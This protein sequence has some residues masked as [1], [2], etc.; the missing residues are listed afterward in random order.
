MRKITITRAKGGFV[1]E[2][3]QA[4]DPIVVTRLVDALAVAADSLSNLE[5]ASSLIGDVMI[6]TPTGRAS[7]SESDQENE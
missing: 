3:S 5:Y 4:T 6:L 7:D 1:I 2:G